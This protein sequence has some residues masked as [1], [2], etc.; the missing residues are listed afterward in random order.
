MQW[1]GPCPP[2]LIA[3]DTYTEASLT[4][5]HRHTLV[6]TGA[7]LQALLLRPPPLRRASQQRHTG[8]LAVGLPAKVC[9]ACLKPVK[10]YREHGLASVQVQTSGLG[11]FLALSVPAMTPFSP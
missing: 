4:L 8:D 10:D 9:G 6:M 2:L 7:F 1:A 11:A 3:L 5:T